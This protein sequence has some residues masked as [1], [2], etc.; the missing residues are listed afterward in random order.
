ME[1]KITIKPTHH[2]KNCLV[3]NMPVLKDEVCLK[4]KQLGYMNG[5]N[6]GYVCKRHL[7]PEVEKNESKV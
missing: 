6:I 4:I 3:C 1:A 7:K 5:Y 2:K